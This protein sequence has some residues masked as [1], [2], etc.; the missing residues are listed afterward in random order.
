MINHEKMQR[1]NTDNIMFCIYG[2]LIS[3]R[4]QFLT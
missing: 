1:F 3:Q 4:I 2:W